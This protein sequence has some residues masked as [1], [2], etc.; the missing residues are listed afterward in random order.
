LKT[1][2]ADVNWTMQPHLNRWIIGSINW[3]ISQ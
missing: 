3:L 2:L 1:K